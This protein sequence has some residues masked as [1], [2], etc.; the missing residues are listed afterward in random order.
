VPSQSPRQIH[1]QSATVVREALD[2]AGIPHFT[3]YGQRDNV[4]FHI[5]REAM[6]VL[7]AR[8]SEEAAGLV[9]PSTIYAKRDTYPGVIL[10]DPETGVVEIRRP[11][12]HTFETRN[13]NTGEV[14]VEERRVWVVTTVSK[15][16]SP[17]DPG[18]DAVRFEEVR[19][20]GRPS[21]MPVVV[22]VSE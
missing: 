4:L 12:V 14:K 15:I 5:D 10:A 19:R 17:E 21:V 18:M 6:P 16:T 11:V 22:A 9:P 7:T 1:H 2:T 8:Y 20:P 13:L 3:R